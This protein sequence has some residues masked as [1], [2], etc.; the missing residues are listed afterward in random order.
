MIRKSTYLIVCM[1]HFFLLSFLCMVN[2]AEAE[3]VL[4]LSIPGKESEDPAEIL[5]DKNGKASLQIM[6]KAYDKNALKNL[7]FILTRF[8]GQHDHKADIKFQGGGYSHTATESGP[9]SDLDL[10]CSETAYCGP[11]LGVLIVKTENAGPAYFN[12][13]LGRDEP[14]WPKELLKADGQTANVQA[15]E[16]GDAFISLYTGD[17]GEPGKKPDEP[18]RKPG[19]PKRKVTLTLSPFISAY[20]SETVKFASGYEISPTNKGT[21]AIYNIT[22]P[23]GIVTWGLD[24]SALKDETPYNGTLTI[25]TQKSN[26]AGHHESE[27]ILKRMRIEL[28]RIAMEKTA[29]IKA[30]LKQDV[31]TCETLWG[32]CEPDSIKI[33]LTNES[34][35]QKIIGLYGEWEE[36]LPKHVE[37]YDTVKFYLATNPLEPG[38]KEVDRKKIPIDLCNFK[39][40]KEIDIER[41]SILPKSQATLYVKLSELKTGQ[42]EL[43]LVLH[44][45]N[46]KDNQGKKVILKAIVKRK[47]WIPVAVLFFS[48]LLSYLVT[49]GYQNNQKFHELEDHIEKLENTWWLKAEC[50]NMFPIVQAHTIIAYAKRAMD[51]FCFSRLWA[52]QAMGKISQDINRLET[53]YM[54]YLERLSRLWINWHYSNDYVMVRHRACHRIRKISSEM[55]K[56]DFLTQDL[57]EI[58]IQD[59]KS[60]EDWSIQK[61]KESDYINDL[62]NAIRS[63][64]E[65]IF[66]ENYKNCDLNLIRDSKRKL[67][68][69]LDPSKFSS[70]VD[71]L[72]KINLDLEQRKQNE[73]DKVKKILVELNDIDFGADDKLLELQSNIANSEDSKSFLNALFPAISQ[74]RKKKD[75]KTKITVIMETNLNNLSS[76]LTGFNKNATIKKFEEIVEASKELEE[77]LLKIFSQPRIFG[78]YLKSN[79]PEDTSSLTYKKAI[80]IDRSFYAPL[81]LLNDLNDERKKELIEIWSDESRTSEERILLIFDKEKEWVWIDLKKTQIH[82]DHNSLNPPDKIEPFSFKEFKVVPIEN[83]NTSIIS[84]TFTFHHRLVYEWLFQMKNKKDSIT[85]ERVTE[86]PIVAAF[87]SL[88]EADVE[89][90]VKVCKY[91][92]CSD[93][94]THDE[95]ENKKKVGSLLFTTEKSTRLL[96]IKGSVIYD[97]FIFFLAYAVAL[98]GALKENHFQS[99]ITDPALSLVVLFMWGVGIDQI[100]NQLQKFTERRQN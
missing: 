50:S 59:I 68:D 30:K 33:Q 100:K 88:R 22:L 41:R 61:N 1:V 62:N 58:V 10:D 55:N 13:S 40:I 6:D 63:L 24:A 54:P 73:A 96:R 85:I 26:A 4:N 49:T 27:K 87:C 66:L 95:E 64:N 47:I 65:C 92:G 46:E 19:E 20:G 37:E 71:E 89:V 2:G 5:I 44:S 38:E 28:T 94:H 34:S 78:K 81:K 15:D 82:V 36:P 86:E 79:L 12:L 91:K 77:L 11:Y 45:M 39:S 67:N 31:S 25:S 52:N 76:I 17:L 83:K 18:E 48:M 3:N 99:A 32:K 7:E 14:A 60:L 56:F 42:Y 72:K 57:S 8:Q 35:S 23:E 75:R 80:D 21:T 69:L 98:F 90:S 43:P 97:I 53:K 51:Q 16:N 74:L 9:L 93:S 70:Y 29:V 84:N